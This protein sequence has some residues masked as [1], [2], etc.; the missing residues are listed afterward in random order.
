M[1]Q[2]DPQIEL[3]SS[4]QSAKLNDATNNPC[5]GRTEYSWSKASGHFLDEENARLAVG[6]AEGR[7]SLPCLQGGQ[8][9]R[10]F[11]ILKQQMFTFERRSTSK[12]TMNGRRTNTGCDSWTLPVGILG[13]PRTPKSRIKVGRI[14][15]DQKRNNRTLAEEKS[16]CWL[17]C[18]DSPPA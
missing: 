18:P 12:L 17:R 1:S 8:V 4:C 11:C 9:G 6:V 10:H 15:R 13:D 14:P 3:D 2:I 7:R 5:S 16:H